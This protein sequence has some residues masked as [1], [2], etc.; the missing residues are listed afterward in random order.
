MD[1]YVVMVDNTKN[2]ETAFK[3]AEKMQSKMAALVLA[4][5]IYILISEDRRKKQNEK[6]QEL[7]DKLK[8]LKTGKGE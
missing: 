1:N 5:G 2:I 7:S 3:C 6:I 4:F 8:E